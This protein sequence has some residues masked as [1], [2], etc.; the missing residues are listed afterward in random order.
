MENITNFIQHHWVLCLI[1]AVLAVLVFIFEAIFG[2]QAA[3]NMLSPQE[4][5]QLMNK[6]EAI[7]VDIRSR[8]AFVRGHIIHSVH[9]PLTDLAK[10]LK[11][12]TQHK[13]KTIVVVCAQG[14]ESSKAVK[15]IEENEFSQVK[16]LK[17]GIAA[18]RADKL[19]LENN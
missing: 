13:H 11:K 14:M 1:F 16:I 18:W 10:D 5:V 3:K 7:V 12:I 19:P 4:T 6:D 2:Q 8:D 9:L 15:I 17:G